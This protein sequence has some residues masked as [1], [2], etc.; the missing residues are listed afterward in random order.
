MLW[1]VDA[2]PAV[3]NDPFSFSMSIYDQSINDKKTDIPQDCKASEMQS[4]AMILVF[5]RI[6]TFGKWKTKRRNSL[7]IANDLNGFTTEL[8]HFVKNSLSN[9]LTIPDS[10]NYDKVQLLQ[11]SNIPKDN[12][13]CPESAFIRNSIHYFIRHIRAFLFLIFRNVKTMPK[14]FSN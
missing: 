4:Y 6:I 12:F 7:R 3:K 1:V 8:G 9:V 5:K 11:Y 13:V 10:P 2:P 14:R